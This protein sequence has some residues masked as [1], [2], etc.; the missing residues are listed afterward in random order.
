MFVRNAIFHV[1][2]GYWIFKLNFAYIIWWWQ[3]GWRDEW[4]P[5]FI[6]KFWWDVNI[7]SV[8]E[9]DSAKIGLGAL[10]ISCN[11]NCVVKASILAP[12]YNILSCLYQFSDF[13]LKS[14]KATITNEIWLVTS[15]I[16]NSRLSEKWPNISV[17]WLGDRY[18]EMKLHSLFPITGLNII[19]YSARTDCPV[20]TML[21]R[22][23]KFQT[24]NRQNIF[25][26]R[27]RTSRS[28]WL[29]K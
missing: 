21:R 24:E 29:L 27:I 16:I 3:F 9:K 18:K 5:D 23:R 14:P 2:G 1:C 17:G 15:S 19:I 20:E 6:T 13:T 11:P 7:K 26:K 4:T 28:V 10:I 25:K 22:T 8:Q 12:P